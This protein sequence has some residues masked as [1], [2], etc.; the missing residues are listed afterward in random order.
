MFRRARTPAVHPSSVNRPSVVLP[1]RPPSGCCREH[2]SCPPPH[3]ALPCVGLALPRVGPEEQRVLS[4]GGVRDGRRPV[5]GLGPDCPPSPL[6]P[7]GEGRGG[8]L[9]SRLLCIP[10]ASCIPSCESP[11]RHPPP[12]GS[13]CLSSSRAAEQALQTRRGGSDNTRVLPAVGRLTSKIQVS[14]GW[15]L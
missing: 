8:V 10:A 2:R 13:R 3:A 6:S 7:W 1:C 11:F 12:D 14:Q 15:F 4:V 5:C 9:P